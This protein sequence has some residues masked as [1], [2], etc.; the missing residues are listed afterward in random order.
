MQHYNIGSIKENTMFC[1][2]VVLFVCFCLLTGCGIWAPTMVGTGVTGISFY[3]NGRSGDVYKVSME[4]AYTSAIRTM[5]ALALKI[6]E[7]KKDEHRRIITANDPLSQ[8]QVTID[9]EGMR[10]GQYIKVSFKALKHTVF[11][12]RLYSRMIMKEFNDKLAQEKGPRLYQA[13]T[14]RSE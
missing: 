8:C 9:L 14:I 6:V 5:N 7:I 10:D 3:H 2:G 1:K 12:D 11:P 13:K 4:K